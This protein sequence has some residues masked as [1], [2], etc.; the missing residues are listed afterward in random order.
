MR[1][2][3]YWAG[4]LGM[5]G[6]LGL[7]AYLCLS[8]LGVLPKAFPQRRA[9]APAGTA[10]L[11]F[12]EALAWAFAALAVQWAAA[13]LAQGIVAGGLAG[14]WEGFWQRFTTAGDS[15]HYLYLAQYGYAA[16]EDKRNL[17]VKS[18]AKRS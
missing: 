15:P 7:M 13:L 10:P 16:A 18:E 17:I 9:P 4:S 14:F 5:V 8:T 6:L 3:L 1:N 11:G 2:V 12:G